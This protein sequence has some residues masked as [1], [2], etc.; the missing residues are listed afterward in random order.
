[1]KKIWAIISTVLVTGLAAGTALACFASE[2]SKKETKSEKPKKET[3]PK[4]PIPQKA[5]DIGKPDKKRRKQV[6]SS[7][8][9][10]KVT[11]DVSV[12]INKPA[13]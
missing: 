4:V 8:S 1:M 3:K 9:R 2:M 5:A 11:R 10:K 12:G 7:S 6:K 13:E